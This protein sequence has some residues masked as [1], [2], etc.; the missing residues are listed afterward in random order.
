MGFKCLGTGALLS[1]LMC[2]AGSSRADLLY[3]TGVENPD[4]SLPGLSN[5]PGWWAD[6]ASW[7]VGGDVGAHE[8]TCS[9]T[10][11]LYH[12]PS[13]EQ[14]FAGLTTTIPFTPSPQT[15]GVMVGAWALLSDY[16][17][18]EPNTYDGVGVGWAGLIMGTYDNPQAAIVM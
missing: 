6:D 8:G 16:P 12:R 3:S 1:V 10:E 15:P 13:G 11:D 17:N 18:P 7:I 14:H 4:L 5:Y 9:A 2:A